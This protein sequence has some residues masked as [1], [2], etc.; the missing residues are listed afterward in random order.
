MR[1]PARGCGDCPRKLTQPYARWCDDCRW[2]HRGKQP[3]YI[4]TPEKD[5]IL[6]AKYEGRDGIPAAIAATF[7]WP[8]WV[9]KKRAAL[10]GLT[11]CPKNRRAWTPE[12]VRF[13]EDHAGTRLVA[14]IAKRLGRSITSVVLKLKHMHISRRIREGYTLRDLELC[15]G[16]D[17][18]AIDGWIRRGL[19][20]GRHRHGGEQ[21]AF[22]R[23]AWQFTDEGLLGFIRE[24]PTAFE[25][26]RVDQTWFMDLV[27]AGGLLRAAEISKEPAA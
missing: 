24:N 4:W 22:E 1:R 16:V 2:R 12:E 18:H 27:L 14:Y 7:G 17:H 19:L 3:I 26:R 13:L 15:F 5:A 23:D 20:R 21:R 10:L 11:A 8:S 9:I 6:K 25:L